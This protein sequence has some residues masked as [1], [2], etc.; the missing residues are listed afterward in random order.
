M[1]KLVILGVLVMLMVGTSLRLVR[2]S[3][4]RISGAWHE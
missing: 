2:G 4:A 3:R 1:E